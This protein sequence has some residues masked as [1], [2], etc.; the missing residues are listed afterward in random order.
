MEDKQEYVSPIKNRRQ[1]S[2]I[3][4]CPFAFNDESEKVQGYGCIP[5]PYEIIIM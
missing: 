4:C 3:G 2:T 1:C 5:T